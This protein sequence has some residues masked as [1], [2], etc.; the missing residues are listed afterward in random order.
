MNK[1]VEAL[2]A[3]VNATQANYVTVCKYGHGG[4]G[5]GL[6]HDTDAAAR[7]TANALGIKLRDTGNDRESWLA[8]DRHLGDVTCSVYGP[9]HK[10]AAKPDTEA[11][12]AAIKLAAEAVAS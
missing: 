7:D 3:L 10:R 8:G 2:A 5:I 11:T 12:E 6:A 4:V 1:I 9:H